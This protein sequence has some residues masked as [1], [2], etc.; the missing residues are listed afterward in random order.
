LLADSDE[1]VRRRAAQGLVGS[2]NLSDEATEA[3]EALLRA[4]KIG[5]DGPALIAFLRKRS[6]AAKDRDHL[7]D[8]V[9]QLGHRQFRKRQ[10]ASVEL[11][12]AGTPALRYLRPAMKDDNLEIA[13]RAARCVAQIEQGPG[14]A[15]PAAAVRWLVRVAPDKAA[16]VLLGYVPSADDEHV[17]QTV[18]AGLCM[19]A[20]REAKLDPAFA[21]GLKNPEPG[22]RAAAAYVLG[23]AGLAADCRAVAGLLRDPDGRVRLR[24]AQALVYAQ[25][26]A[27]IPVLVKLLD[28]NQEIPVRTLAEHVLRRL[29]RHLAPTSSVVAGTAAERQE[30]LAAWTGWSRDH[31]QSVVLAMADTGGDQRNLTLVVEFDGSPDNRGQIWEFGRD[32][33]PRWTLDG[34]QGPSDADVLPGNKVLLVE[35]AGRRVSE[36]DLKGNIIWQLET[37]SPPVACQRLADGHT[38]VATASSLIEIDGS[39]EEVSN[40]NREQDGSIVC[41]QKVRN[42]HVVYITDRGR[43]VEFD[44]QGDGKVVYR[45]NVGNPGGPCGVEWLPNGRYLVALSGPGKIMEV[46]RGGR[47]LWEVKVAGAHQ[48]LPLPNGHYLVACQSPKRL[49]EVDLAGKII[50]E[51]RTRGRPI[52]IHR[53]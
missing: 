44:P 23:R 46:D 34:L 36:R 35:A 52:R 16:E 42:G 53:R 33:R 4:N 29:A 14:T 37:E 5:T 7:R 19:L 45:F 47:V 50:W 51:K 48:A 38:M 41:A 11:V 6:L 40:H 2:A 43:V 26:R 25:D 31:G 17:E 32:V 28:L 9:L 49:A 10:Q 39:Q 1:Q 8:L 13:Q 22:S 24:A 20:V 18:M 3:D 15:L 12:R 27:A 21:A 30:A